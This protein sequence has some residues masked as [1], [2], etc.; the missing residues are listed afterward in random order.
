MKRIRTSWIVLLLTAAVAAQEGL[1]IPAPA[2]P[3]DFSQRRADSTSLALPQPPDGAPSQR[4]PQPDAGGLS[5]EEAPQPDAAFPAGQERPSN[6]PLPSDPSLP[7][8][9]VFPY[10][11]AFAADPTSPSEFP[12]ASE[13]PARPEYSSDPAFP[14]RPELPPRVVWR[15]PLATPVLPSVRRRDGL[16]ARIYV[17]NNISLQIGGYVNLT[18]GQ[19]WIWS[20]Y[21]NGYLDAR[22]LSMPLPR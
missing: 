17:I 22:T 16:P 12:A 4:A 18:N 1:R 14:P 15:P 3:A 2:P 7:S 11:P 9:P 10:D 6:R 8:D 21:P 5:R 20:P 13:F 19:A